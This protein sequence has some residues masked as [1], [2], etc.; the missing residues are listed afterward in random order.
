M[1]VLIVI[2]SGGIDVSFTAIGVFALYAT[3]KLMLY[4]APG[5]PF[6]RHSSL[7]R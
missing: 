1:G 4:F 2:I 6:G 3:V 7:R 5:T